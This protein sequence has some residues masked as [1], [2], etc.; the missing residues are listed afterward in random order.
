M[1]SLPVARSHEPDLSATASE[2]HVPSDHVRSPE[3]KPPRREGS[4]FADR[5]LTIIY[6][7][8]DASRGRFDF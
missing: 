3:A 5:L 4:G 1:H 2:Y 6:R 8:V 7:A